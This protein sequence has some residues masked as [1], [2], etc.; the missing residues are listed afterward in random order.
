MALSLKKDLF[1]ASLIHIYINSTLF[2]LLYV[3]DIH[4]NT[5]VDPKYIEY[6][7]QNS[8][9]LA[10]LKQNSEYATQVFA[11]LKMTVQCS[12]KNENFTVDSAEYGDI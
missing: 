6:A 5:T 11:F 2:R 10:I 8:P 1:A 7:T 4:K 3:S 12:R 9:F